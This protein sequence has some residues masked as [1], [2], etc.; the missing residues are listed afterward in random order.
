M[1]PLKKRLERLEGH[2]SR[3]AL[4]VVEQGPDGRLYRFHG[5]GPWPGEAP[6]DPEEL[7]GKTVLTVVYEGGIP[8]LT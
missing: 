2:H 7:K 6:I 1:N 3:G 4:L 5:G 8:C